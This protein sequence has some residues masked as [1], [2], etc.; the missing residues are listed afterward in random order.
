MG[1]DGDMEYSSNVTIYP[2]RVSGRI[3]LENLWRVPHTVS[4]IYKE[5]FESIGAGPHILAGLGLRAIVEAVCV[6]EGATQWD[7]HKKISYLVS[8][9]K[10]TRAGGDLLLHNSRHWK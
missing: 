1:D 8:T 9:D 5:T 4:K 6:T 3:Q 10:L 7:F 2:H